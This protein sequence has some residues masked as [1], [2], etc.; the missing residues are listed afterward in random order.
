MGAIAPIVCTCN[1]QPASQ[2]YCYSTAALALATISDMS[3]RRGKIRQGNTA[4]RLFKLTISGKRL[5]RW[6]V[7]AHYNTLINACSPRGSHFVSFVIPGLGHVEGPDHRC[8]EYVE[9]LVCKMPSGTNPE[10]DRSGIMHMSYQGCTRETT[11]LRPNPNA[12]SG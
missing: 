8:N 7:H 6:K 5:A 11:H 4:G 2:S 10:F 1:K 12:S 9:A 3:W